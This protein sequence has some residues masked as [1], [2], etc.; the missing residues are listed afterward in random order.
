MKRTIL[1]LAACLFLAIAGFALSFETADH[2]IRGPDSIICST[3]YDLIAP[4]SAPIYTI[5][6]IEVVREVDIG[7]ITMQAK[8]EKRDVALPRIPASKLTGHATEVEYAYI[9]P[10]LEFQTGNGTGFRGLGHNH[11]ARADV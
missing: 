5:R 11:F 7:D 2:A 3:S 10:A 8:T 1:T 6:A 9:G 4:T